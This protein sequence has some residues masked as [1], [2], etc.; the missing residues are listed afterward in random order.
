METAKEKAI[1]SLMIDIYLRS[2]PSKR[3]DLIK[4]KTYA[5][6]RIEKC[7]F[8]A[9]KTFCSNCHVHC[10]EAKMRSLIRQVMRYSGPRMIFYHP[11]IAVSHFISSIKERRKICRSKG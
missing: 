11:L 9:T 10:Y 2:H 6:K 3:D 4:L 8:A 1:V 7:P 5:F